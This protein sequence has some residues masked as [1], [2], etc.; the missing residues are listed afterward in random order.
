MMFRFLGAASALAIGAESAFSNA[1]TF[2][3]EAQLSRERYL[4]AA[5]RGSVTR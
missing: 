5:R 3:R 2:E 1:R 4:A